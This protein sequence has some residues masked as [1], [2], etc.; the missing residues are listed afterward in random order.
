M[1][2]WFSLCFIALGTPLALWLL[3][4]AG[5]G[6][7]NKPQKHQLPPGP[8]TL[9]IIGSLHHVVSLVPHRKITQLCRRYGPMMH[10]KLGEVEAVVISSAEAVAQ[11]MK[12]NDLA[13]ATRPGTPT[14]DIAG[15]GGRGIIFAPYCDHWR[16]M[17]KVCIVELLSSMQVRRMESIRPEEVGNLLADIATAAASGDSINISEKMMEL[18]NVVSQAVFGGRFTQQDE[19]IRELDVVLTLLGGFCLVD[20]FPS[21]RL[22]RW[23]SFARCMKRSYSHMQCIIANVIE[24]RKA[25]RATGH[26]ASSTHDE[27]LLDVLLRL[28]NDDSLAFP[29]TTESICAVL[30]DIFSGA[31]DTTG[32][33]FEWAMSELVRHPETMFKAQLEI[34][35]VLGQ[36]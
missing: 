18:N 26:G 4:L 19:Y 6:G 23:L 30:F 8:W 3:K 29:L 12:T 9:P 5:A 27:D 10:L 7:K 11:V 34:R 14:Q 33:I 35:K 1:E 15:C 25:A 21:S 2:G 22:A 13:F 16:Q 36:D 31:T 28:Q 20:L 32:T 17:R 24:E